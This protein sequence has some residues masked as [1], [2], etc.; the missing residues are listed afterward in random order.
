MISII[1]PAHNEGSVIARTLGSVLRGADQDELDVIVVC[2]G[3]SDDTASV[4]SKFSPT[5]RVLE[6]ST[7]SKIAA[8][9]LGD[10]AARSFPRIYLD[11]DVTI[12]I[13]TVRAISERLQNGVL[14]AAPTPAFDLNGCS[15]PVRAYYA[16]RARL[17]S[18]RQGVGGSGVYALSEQ[19]RARFGAFPDVVAD[20]TYVRLQFAP[21]ERE[22]IRSLTSTVYAPRTVR[23]LTQVRTR[24]YYGTKELQRRFPGIFRNSDSANHQ[25]LLGLAANPRHWLG[26]SIYLWVNAVARFR[27]HAALRRKAFQWHHDQSSRSAS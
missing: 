6:T 3:C 22:T 5:V 14:L 7:A 1:I 2:N 24:T 17:P 15:W 27:A 23:H 26:L 13:D 18:A 16:L 20:D 19:G 12:T 11:A 21:S 8:L 25:T 4:A 10:Q 9:N